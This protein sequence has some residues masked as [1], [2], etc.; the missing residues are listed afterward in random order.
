MYT[1]IYVILYLLTI[2]RI[3]ENT[4]YL[5]PFDNHIIFHRMYNADIYLKVAKRPLPMAQTI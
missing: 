2:S 5:I 3:S 4:D 1:F